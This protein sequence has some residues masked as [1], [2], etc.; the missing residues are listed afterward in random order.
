LADDVTGDR[1]VLNGQE[2]FHAAR[3]MRVSVGE[4]AG[5]TDGRGAVAT[6]TV[7]AS[8]ADEVVIEVDEHVAVPAPRPRLTLFPA[9]P[10]KGKLDL[11]VQ[12]LTEMGVWEV[13]AWFAERSIARWNAA[14][15][16]ATE[17]RLALIARAAVKQA[18]LAWLP[19]VAVDEEFFGW[20]GPA[21]VCHEAATLRLRDALPGRAEDTFALVTGPEGGLTD[22]EV[23]RFEASGASIVSLGEPILRAET[24]TIVASALVLGGFHLLG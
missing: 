3:A 17:E 5:V 20:S 19:S 24:A 9:V 8:R 21:V 10:T 11:V 12:K 6:G 7:V 2:A 13:R 18:R 22:A 23:A 1:I 4:R 15:R 14:K 16:R